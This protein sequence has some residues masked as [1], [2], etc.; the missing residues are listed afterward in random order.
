MPTIDDD[1]LKQALENEDNK[2]VMNLDH[3]KIKCIKNDMLQKLQLPKEKLKK[4]HAKLKE[5]RL[6][7][8]ISDLHYG[9]HIRWINLNKPHDIKLTNGAFICD[10]KIV[11]DGVHIGCRGFMGRM[12]QVKMNENIIFQKITPD[13]HIILSVMDYLNK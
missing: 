5:Y 10:I 6:V 13:E 1:L 3:A 2:S 12:F 4:L 9:S 7:D 11:D 8:E